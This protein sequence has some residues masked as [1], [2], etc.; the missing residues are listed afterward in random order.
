MRITRVYIDADLTA[1]SVITLPDTVRHH[2]VTVLRLKPQYEFVTF[3]GREP[4][5]A[6]ARL[7]ELNKKTGLAEILDIAPANRES[8]LQLTLIQSI[9]SAEKMDFTIQKAVELGVQTIQPVYSSHS[10]RRLKSVQLEKKLQH[11]QGVI[12][13][14][15]EQ[16]G[17]TL[18]PQLL[19]VTDLDR[20]LLQR[21]NEISLLAMDPLATLALPQI[22]AKLGQHIGIIVGPEGGFSE[23]E[24]MLMANTVDH[25]VHMGPRILRT[26]T[27]AIAALSWLQIQCGDLAT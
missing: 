9:S 4:L 7:L 27:A 3:N 5:E 8:T 26:E 22:Q 19:A 18:V 6:R 11:W 16:S 12:I 24:R 1:G 20:Y 13:H 25:S 15:C 14:A 17:R 21:P 2:L 10:Q 23:N